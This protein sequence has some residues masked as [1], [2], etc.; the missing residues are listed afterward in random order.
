MMKYLILFLSLQLKVVPVFA[1]GNSDSMAQESAL[2]KISVTTQES[3]DY[4]ISNRSPA[5]A[6]EGSQVK[7]DVTQ[8]K[9][10]KSLIAFPP[11][12]FQG[13]PAQVKNYEAIGGEIFRVIT[14]DLTFTSFF[15]FISQAAYLEDVRKTSI[16]PISADPNGFNYASWKQLETDFLIRGAF[17]IAGEDLSLEVYVYNVRKETSVLS[18]KYKGNTKALRRIAHSAANDFM[19]ALTG[20]KGAFLSRVVTASDRGGGKFK[21]IYLMDWDGANIDKITNHKSVTLSPAWSPDASKVAYTAF[22]QRAKT[23]TRNADLFIYELSTGKRWLA[24]YKKGIN[25]GANFD[26]K[27]KNLFLTI[28]QSGS[29]DIFKITPEGEELARLT[30]GPRG[31]MNVE[32]AVS[33]DGKKLAFSSDRSGNPMVYVMDIDGSNVKRITFAGR[34]NATPSWSPDGK[35]LAFAGWS[36]DHFDIF[37]VNTDG[38][39]M[40]RITS[41]RKPNGKWANNETPVYSADGR[42]LMYTSNRT[43]VNQIFISNLDGSEERRITNDDANYFS[44]KWSD[45]IE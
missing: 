8:A 3:E 2:P 6:T 13:N 33:P 37:T 42:M 17:S 20:T 18:K 5:S 1:Q 10:K 24:S 44:P 30:N 22:V 15:Q 4:P 11:L 29:P 26:T 43:G 36:I 25:S 45:N 7:I 27:S 23:K 31:A 14:N 34:Y 28:S 16:K 35:R 12:Q 41:S 40:L 38:S 39:D 21:E 32:P 19:E 9:A